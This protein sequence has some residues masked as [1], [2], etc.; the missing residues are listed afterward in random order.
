MHDGPPLRG[1]RLYRLQWQLHPWARNRDR[2]QVKRLLY[3][4]MYRAP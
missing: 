3:E 1:L 2:P 4:V